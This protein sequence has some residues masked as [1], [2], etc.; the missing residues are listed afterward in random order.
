MSMR[1][2]PLESIRRLIRRA[3][4]P[5]RSCYL[6]VHDWHY[7]Q[8]ERVPPKGTPNRMSKARAYFNRECRDCRINENVGSRRGP[9]GG[10]IEPSLFAHPDAER[11]GDQKVQAMFAAHGLNADG[12]APLKSLRP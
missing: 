12:T 6:G 11:R 8:S 1:T 3:V 10:D 9:V 2:D 4:R 7:W 5:R